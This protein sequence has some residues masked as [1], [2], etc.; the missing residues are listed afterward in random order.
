VTDDNE[1]AELRW[2]WS[3]AY[4]ITHPRLRTWLAERRDTHE[5]LRAATADEL[6]D[7]IRDDY[8]DRPVPRLRARQN[9]GIALL[10][11]HLQ[12]ERELGQCPGDRAALR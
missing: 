4:A 8:A 10:L 5:V 7:L 3:S 6:L 12:P 2:H 1:L 11:R 9:P